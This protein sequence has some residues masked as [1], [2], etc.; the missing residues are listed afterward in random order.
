[1]NQL[2]NRPFSN[3]GGFQEVA[4]GEDVNPGNLVERNRDG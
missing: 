3:I 2:K 4:Y 1:M